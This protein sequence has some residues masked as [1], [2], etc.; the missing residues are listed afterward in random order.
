[1]PIKITVTGHP[2]VTLNG[3]EITIGRDP[4]CQISLPHEEDLLP[5]HAVIR[6][7]GERWQIAVHKQAMPCL[8]NSEATRSH[9]V[10][11]G[12]EIRFTENGAVF[13]FQSDDVDDFMPQVPAFASDPGARTPLPPIVV[14]PATTPR[15]QNPPTS[16]TIPATG[17]PL[18]GTIPAGKSPSSATIKTTAPLS[19]DSIPER[20]AAENQLPNERP[21]GG[22]QTPFVEDE[23]GDRPRPVE[24]SGI[25]ISAARLMK[26]PSSATIKTTRPP[27]STTI[28]TTKP[29]SSASIRTTKPQSS[30]TIKTTKPPSSATI[31]TADSAADG[32]NDQSG[33]TNRSDAGR[34]STGPKQLRSSARIP[35]RAPSDDEVAEGAPVLQRLSSWDDSSDMGE[36]LP[37]RGRSREQAEIKWIL[38]VVG[39]SFAAGGVLLVVWL[40]GSALMKSLG[41]PAMSTPPLSS[42]TSSAD[43]NTNPSAQI[44]IPPVVAPVAP[45]PKPVAV[46]PREPDAVAMEET[47]REE[48]EPMD[49]ITAEAM[50]DGSEHPD[51][52][53]GKSTLPD[54]ELDNA[55]LS[56]VLQATQNGVY[57]VI[58]ED[59][60]GTRRIRIGTAWAATERHLVTTASIA[61]AVQEYQQE[62][63]IASVV[64]PTSKQSIRIEN[65]RT[66]K[67]FR[68]GE[69]SIAKA[70]EKGNEKM[71]LLAQAAQVRFDLGVLDIV[72]SGE[73]DNALPFVARSMKTSKE[74]KFSM[75]GFPFDR[76]DDFTDAF[77]VGKL[78]LI[79]S[80]K[81]TSKQIPQNKEMA[82]TIQF[83]SDSD[84]RDWSGSPVLNRANQVIGVYAQ[85]A[86]PKMLLSKRNQPERAVVWLGRL[87]DFAADVEKFAEKSEKVLTKLHQ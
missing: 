73:L 50:G 83:A 54:E 63:L 41:S 35:V 65:V 77:D 40:A 12:D 46:V 43:S 79:G 15:N 74:T 52:T 55:P 45:K 30:A 10:T 6:P 67:F 31:R 9:W 85:L 17:L 51:S 38:M 44:A 34:A 48:S 60:E 5:V 84:D 53:T 39:R 75:V 76:D 32:A 24:D 71:V 82:L 68:E 78:A 26:S 72:D 69:D 8:A 19:A 3:H 1:M 47:D 27:S 22:G 23:K 13:T 20:R 21:A 28:P 86:D 14:P 58:A 64:H 56:P 29:P 87:H 37:K 25:N 36:L 57:A 59:D 7:V 70:I 33:T 16:G 66:H 4:R 49:P 42:I 81:F 62:G 2:Q 61:L 11:P 18:S 80:K